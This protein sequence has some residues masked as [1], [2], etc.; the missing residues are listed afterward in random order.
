L[1]RSRPRGACASSGSTDNGADGLDHLGDAAFGIL[2]LGVGLAEV[3]P[4]LDG[5]GRQLVEEL[6]PVLGGEQL[7]QPVSGE[8]R[9]AVLGD[10]QAIEGRLVGEGR[11]GLGAGFGSRGPGLCGVRPPLTTVEIRAVPP[12]ELAVVGRLLRTQ[13]GDKST[14]A[15]TGKPTRR[16]TA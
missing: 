7:C 4:A 13:G 2:Q 14:G 11:T 3:G 1:A 16:S 15:A 5:A 10:E 6:A 12:E 9:Q 8:D